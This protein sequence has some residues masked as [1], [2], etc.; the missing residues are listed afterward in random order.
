MGSIHRDPKTTPFL[1]AITLSTM[2]G[3]R[4]FKT[5]FSFFGESR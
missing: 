1:V 5:E 4:V 3:K 2:A